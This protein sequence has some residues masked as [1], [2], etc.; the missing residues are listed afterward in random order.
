[1]AQAQT[2][3]Q[4]EA[5]A[6]QQLKNCLS[7]QKW[8]INNLYWITNKQGQRVKF[9]MNSAQESLYDGMH[10]LNLI[11][12]ARQFGGTTFTDIFYLDS[13]HFNSNHSA[14]IIA[15][16]KDD[17]AKIF[18]SKVLYPWRNLQDDIRRPAITETRHELMFDNNSSIR[19]GTSMRSA[20]L[21]KLH[22]SEFGKICAK[23]PDKAKEI[24][25]GAL[26][27]VQAGQIVTIESTAEGRGGYFYEYC[28]EALKLQRAMK[29]LTAMDWKIFFFPWFDNPD[30]QIDPEGVVLTP[31]NEQYFEEL[32][33]KSGIRLSDRQK[34][35]YVK[36]ERMMEA[37][38]K[39]AGADGEDMKREYPSTPEEA[40]YVSVAGAF[41]GKQM[42]KARAEGRICDSLPHNPG[43]PVHTAWDIGFD[44]DAIWFF[45]VIGA[46]VNVIDYYAT[47]GEGLPHC[48]G[49]LSERR[50]KF[51]YHYGHHFGPHDINHRDWGTAN[52]RS[53]TARDLGIVFTQIPRILTQGDGIE[54]VR[55]T[56]PMC[57]FD[58]GKCDEGIKCLDSYRKKWDDNKGCFTDTPLHD[59]A[60]HGAKAFESL[61][62]G[63]R[64]V[65]SF[66]GTA[67]G[68][69]SKNKW[70]EA[71]GYGG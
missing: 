53:D 38:G 23:Y 24:V 50:E 66:S 48:V 61:S 25:T 13:C 11:L 21:Q 8:R 64:N 1:M 30:Y 54:A 27:A 62:F 47:E 55:K 41:Y 45:Q 10:Y 51:K 18:E 35:W 59:W 9:H 32:L 65:A 60:S 39:D 43:Y 14:G 36:K 52:E 42:T 28:M 67:Q 46:W 69:R 20:T 44:C 68:T 49:T 40:F 31:D 33:V 26:N 56:L 19:I 57:R 4:H 12:K 29:K 70:A 2:C 71:G 17:A 58:A 7:N 16:H 63:L 15:H 3:P 6:E 37:N 34:A 22:I 5:N